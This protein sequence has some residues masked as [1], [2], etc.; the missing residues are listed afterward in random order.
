M[1]ATAELELEA[2]PRGAFRVPEVCRLA[3]VTYRQLDYWDRQGIASPTVRPAG[4]SGTQRVY[5][6]LDIRRLRL[7]ARLA[8]CGVTPGFFAGLTDREVADECARLAAVA[9]EA[10]ELVE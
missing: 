2:R 10:R 6:A 8:R 4:G 1:E 3:G 5:S 9:V 7:V